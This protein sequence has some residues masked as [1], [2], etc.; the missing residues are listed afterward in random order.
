MG[1]ERNEEQEF[2]ENIERFLN[3]EEITPDEDSSEDV[4]STME[5]AKKLSELRTE[6]SPEF[7]QSL[8]SRLLI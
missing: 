6:P 8:K 7:H 4:R 3:G 2:L 1:K 5:F